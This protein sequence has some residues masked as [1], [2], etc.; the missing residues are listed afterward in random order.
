MAV[1][2]WHVTELL[3]AKGAEVNHADKAGFTALIAAQQSGDAKRVDLLLKAGADVNA[4][5]SFA[6]RTK[7][8]PIA[9]VGMT[10]LMVAAPYGDAHTI[11]ALLKAGARVNDVDGRKMTALMFAVTTDRANP[12]TVKQL[13]AAG[14]DRQRARPERR[15]GA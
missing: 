1:G 15:L 10:P 5:N 7:N 2:D 12:T 14:A 3:L 6:G 9:L 11:A 13:I 4:A 8:G